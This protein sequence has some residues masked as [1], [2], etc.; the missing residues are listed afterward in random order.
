MLWYRASLALKS[1]PGTLRRISSSPFS[2]TADFIDCSATIVMHVTKK[3]L[4]LL[5]SMISLSQNKHL[6][7][8]NNAIDEAEKR[9]LFFEVLGSSSSGDIGLVDF[10][11]LGFEIS[12]KS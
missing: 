1:R 3:C 4:L 5:I 11:L 8:G 9:F 12:S 10:R 6:S 7:V 2:R